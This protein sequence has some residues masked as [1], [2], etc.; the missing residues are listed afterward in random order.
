MNARSIHTQWLMYACNC[1]K[2]CLFST[3]LRA[4]VQKCVYLH[5]YKESEPLFV[6]G[7]PFDINYKR[8]SFAALD[9]QHIYI[10]GVTHTHTHKCMHRADFCTHVVYSL[11]LFIFDERRKCAHI[12][13]DWSHDGHCTMYVCECIAIGNQL[14]AQKQFLTAPYAQVNIN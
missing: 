4:S 9:T 10:E 3:P 5:S 11:Q 12:E 6:L 1:A 2:Y 7:V 8:Q 13:M 14:R